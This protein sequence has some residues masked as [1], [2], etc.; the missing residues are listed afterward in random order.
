MRKLFGAFVSIV[1]L[2]NQATATVPST[3]ADPAGAPAPLEST[4]TLQL[5]TKSTVAIEVKSTVPAF[6]N[7]REHLIDAQ[8]AKLEASAKAKADAIA[9]AEADAKA[10]AEADAKAKLAQ[11]APQANPVVIVP[12]D[13]AWGQLR[14][15]EAGG[16][17]ARNSGNG[18]YG[19]YQFDIGTWGGYG[20]Y[21]RAD[22]APPAIQDEKARQTQ[23]AR[24]WYPWPA[25]ARKLGLI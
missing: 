15:C 13:D 25:C 4:Y 1:I 3:V 16:N 6:D 2:A 24:G 8:Y 19:A 17:Y 11:S 18:Y 7:V 12:S 23:S 20:G 10:K 22:L 14:Q 5:N 21:A 9:K